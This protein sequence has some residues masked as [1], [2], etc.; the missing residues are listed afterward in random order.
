MTAAERIAAAGLTITEGMTTPTRPGKKPRP[1][2]TVSGRTMPWIAILRGLGGRPWHG[3]FSFFTDPTD[4]LA[5]AISDDRADDTLSG[6]YRERRE[7]RAEDLRE[8]ADKRETRAAADLRIVNHFRGDHAFNF[9]PGHIPERARIIRKQDRAIASLRKAES[10]DRRADSI[11]GAN[12]AAVYDDDTDAIEQLRAR[13]GKL[14]AERERMK[15]CNTAIRKHGLPRLLEADPPFVLTTAERGELLQL[16]QITPYHQ[17][18]KKG[19]PAYALQN[20]GG[21]ITRNRKRLEDLECGDA[22]RARVRAM[23]AAEHEPPQKPEPDPVEAVARE[24]E[25]AERD[26]PPLAEVP[27]SLSAPIARAASKQEDLF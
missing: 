1:V 17:V 15:A 8:W 11:E 20:L 25:D 7:Q 5:D 14:E 9:Q 26:A 23:L 4:A 16:M 27:F 10:M 13:V 6:A 19:F 24:F 18:D 22:Q 21:N 12:A 3:S 2:W